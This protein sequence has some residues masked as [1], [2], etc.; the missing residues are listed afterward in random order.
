MLFFQKGPRAAAIARCLLSG[1]QV[2]VA[3]PNA[4][5]VVA[6]GG[7]SRVRWVPSASTTNASCGA[8]SLVSPLALGRKKRNFRPLGEAAPGQSAR[9]PELLS[10]INP[11][12]SDVRREYSP[13]RVSS[14]GSN[15]CATSRSLPSQEP[16]GSSSVGSGSSN[17]R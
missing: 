11:P 15:P 16:P 10:R 6:P 9:S 7:V 4:N 5:A 2:A 14:V 3:A 8:L 13:D 17:V 12:P 1:D